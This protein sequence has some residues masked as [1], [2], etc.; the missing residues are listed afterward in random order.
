MP[1]KKPT[2]ASRSS[3]SAVSSVIKKDLQKM[4]K[5]DKLLLL[6]ALVTLVAV[7][8]PWYSFGFGGVMKELAPYMAGYQSSMN[9]LSSFGWLTFLGSLAYLLWKV[10]PVMK[11]KLPQMP[12]SDSN[13]H[14]ILA[15]AMLAGPVIWMLQSGF[16]FGVFGFGFW[17][18]L[19]ASAIFSY[20]T[21]TGK[22]VGK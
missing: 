18:A 16:A 8:L 21:F 6:L 4:Q 20:L 9:G 1:P 14:K 13:L 11:V 7:F 12:T 19:V 5:T 22:K 17:I 15:V 2:H 3:K 10:L